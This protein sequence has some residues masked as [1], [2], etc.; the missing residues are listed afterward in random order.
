LIAVQIY[1]LV[2]FLM[3]IMR[4]YLV[5]IDAYQC[6]VE[7][8]IQMPII[9]WL[10][11]GNYLELNSPIFIT[12]LLLFMLSPNF[13]YCIL[14]RERIGVI[15]DYVWKGIVTI[16]FKMGIIPPSLC[17]KRMTSTSIIKLQI[18]CFI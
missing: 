16:L 15:S 2:L 8:R 9:Y 17:W 1:C 4:T 12:M 14:G 5:I 13:C 11:L 7:P 6:L 10:P 18:L 3:S